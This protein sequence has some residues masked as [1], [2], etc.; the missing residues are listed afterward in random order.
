MR[1]LVFGDSIAYGAWDTEGGWVERLKKKAHQTT[2]ES[3]GNKK[4]QILNMGIGGDSSSKVLARMAAEIESRRSN[5]WPFVFVFTFGANDERSI[6]N[7]AET[8]L[9]QFEKN[10]QAII[11]LAKQY[12]DKILFVGIPP[13]SQPTIILKGQEYSDN[14]IQEYEEHMIKILESEKIP[15]VPIRNTFKQTADNLYSYDGLHPNNKGHEL[16]ANAVEPQLFNLL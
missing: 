13:L 9:E 15:F 2:V 5:S 11:T 4:I 10:V 6:N 3:A 16:I 12:S 1:V 8:A 7:E 14:R